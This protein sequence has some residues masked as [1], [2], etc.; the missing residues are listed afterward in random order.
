MSTTI[1]R[2]RTETIQH[3]GWL[4]KHARNGKALPK[5]RWFV[6]TKS[7][8]HYADQEGLQPKMK[9]DLK[10]ARVTKKN[11]VSCFLFWCLCRHKILNM[12]SMHRGGLRSTYSDIITVELIIHM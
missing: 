7:H 6:L 2:P 3:A 8:L 9:W 11:A 5:K 10:D 12:N 1:L 4:I